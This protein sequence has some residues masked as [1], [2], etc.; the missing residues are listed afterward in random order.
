MARVVVLVNE[1]S[2]SEES[3]DGRVASIR[4]A[5]R[6]AGARPPIRCIPGR[7]LVDAATEAVQGG[8]RVV[9]AAGGDG[10]VSAVA[11]VV[12]GT[13]A[14]LAVLPLGTLNHFA[15][16]A[17]LPL[18]L[19]AAATVAVRGVPTRI[20]VAEV[21]GLAYVN[22]V[23]IG[24]YPDAV[25]ERRRLHRPG[26]S[27][28]LAMARAAGTVLHRARGH[29]VLLSIDGRPGLRHTSFVMVGN[30]AY[31]TSLGRLGRRASLTGRCLS[32]YT[33]RRPGRRALVGL[34]ARALVGRVGQA[35]DLESHEASRV[36]V[37]SRHRKLEVGIDGELMRLRTPL[38]FAVR[39]GSLWLMREADA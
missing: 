33:T 12:A 14:A 9:V 2:G 28:A 23:S 29:R 18:E 7:G 19:E 35:P 6:A 31:V 8:A 4:E 20:D 38:R 37:D 5:F 22:N 11:R 25:H 24:L 26:T 1:S 13:D 10:T 36:V 21:N 15:K 32:V 3:G 30:N 27:K 17:G 34:A 16:D 39:P